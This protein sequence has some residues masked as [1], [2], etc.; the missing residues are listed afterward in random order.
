M[1]T[2]LQQFIKESILYDFD[3]DK[4]ETYKQMFQQEYEDYEGSIEGFNTLWEHI[5]TTNFNDGGF[6]NIPD[7]IEL[8]R[9]VNTDK[10]INDRNNIH[11]VRREDEY[12]FQD[13]DW[14]FTVGI[15]ISDNSK[16][17][18]TI[19]NKNDVNWKITIIQNLTFEEEKEITLNKD[20]ILKNY[21]V[22][23]LNESSYNESVYDIITNTVKKKQG[24]YTV[25]NNDFHIIF[26]LT[27]DI[28]ELTWITI[29]T[30]KFTG[31]EVL[32]GLIKYCKQFNITKIKATGVRDKHHGKDSYGY[33]V[34]L[35][36]GFLPIQGITFIND[37]LNTNYKSFENAFIDSNFLPKWKINGIEFDGIFDLNQNSLSMKQFNKQ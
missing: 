13:E 29:N 32:L 9:I 19:V 2:T 25:K 37:V 14:Q 1:I 22:K 17:I 20:Y 8:S 21:K 15:E 31:K 35:K 10:I 12:L 6:K 33:Y 34:M 5:T 27:D 26:D 18:R 7:K 4:L 30:N 3:I 24:I 11:W 23:T 28:L 36:W 16:I